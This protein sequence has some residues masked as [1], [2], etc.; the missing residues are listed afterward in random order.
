MNASLAWINELL[1][2]SLSAREATDRLAMLELADRLAHS[3]SA[4]LAKP[5]LEEAATIAS[6]LELTELSDRI[7]LLGAKVEA[8]HL[9]EHP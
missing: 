9:A 6:G 7:A 4:A 3:P 8:A 5:L 1:G 2:A